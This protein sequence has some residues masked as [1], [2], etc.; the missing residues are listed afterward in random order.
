VFCFFSL[1]IEKPESNQTN[2]YE[3]D[4]DLLQNAL[5]ESL[6]FKAPE[7]SPVVIPKRVDNNKSIISSKISTFDNFRKNEDD[8]DDDDDQ[9]N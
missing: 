4:D 3:S 8:S 1:F 6:R 7:K 9:G 5:E 2:A